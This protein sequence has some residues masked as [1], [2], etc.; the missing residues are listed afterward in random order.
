LETYPPGDAFLIPV[1]LDKCSPSYDRLRE[2]NWVNLYEGWRKGV[3]A[4]L[5]RCLQKETTAP[6]KKD[7]PRLRTD[8]V[9][10]TPTKNSSYRYYYLRFLSD[11]TVYA[12]A[13]DFT[14]LNIFP[15]MT[16][17]NALYLA[18]GKYSLSGTK[19]RFSTRSSSGIIDYNGFIGPNTL[20]LN[21]H[22]KIN[23]FRDVLEYR[24]K[25]AK[26]I[27]IDNGESPN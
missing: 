2:V 4:I 17:N 14:P 15:E 5:R 20:I 21:K 27:K 23:G 3:D 12:V 19:L 16:K 10:Q 22:S 13:S 9:Y 24:F 26:A 25:K 1:R 7:Q 18:V 6:K 8:G 11:K